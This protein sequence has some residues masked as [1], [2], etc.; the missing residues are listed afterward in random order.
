MIRQ[1][2]LIASCLSAWLFYSCTE[3]ND[4]EKALVSA[5]DSTSKT[6]KD[7]GFIAG[8][9]DASESVK[10]DT[11]SGE[12]AEKINSLSELSRH[13]NK[14]P[15][16]FVIKTN[17]D[18]VIK[19]KEG[20]LLSIPANAFLNASNQSPIVGEVKISVKEFYKISDMMIAG[21][22]TASNNQLLE[23]GGMIN[24]KATAKENNDS[25]ILRP[26]KSIVIAMPNQNTN[27]V[28]GM[29]LFNGVHGDNNHTDNNVNWVPQ[30]GTTGLVQ[31]WNVRGYDSYKSLFQIEPGF[32]FPD[33]MPRSKPLIVNSNPEHLQ[34]EIKMPVRDLMQ[35]AGT[36]TRK[37]YGYIDT[38]GNFHCHRIGNSPQKILF[39]GI[40]GPTICQNTKV[41]LPVEANVSFK[42][43]LNYNY[44][45]KLFKMGKGKPDSLVSI[46]ATLKPAVKITSVEKIRPVYK[47]AVTVMEYRK[48]QARQALLLRKYEEKL[49]QLQ[50]DDEEKLAKLE[51]SGNMNLQSAQNYF[52]MSTPGL[53]WI[54]CDRFYNSQAKVDYFVKLKEP[55]SLLIV[56][57]SIK[58]IISASG[59]GV[60]ASVPLNE[61][62]TIVGLKTEQGRLMMAMHETTVTK[63]SFDGLSFKP[64]TV[65]EYRSQ[66]EKLNRF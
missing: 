44:F 10:A 37:A 19:C 48:K 8:N 39:A 58:S 47:N 35:P 32:L 49:K 57:S 38:S 14:K 21:L 1:K 31:N 24:I 12:V 61:K 3:S 52:L 64:V 29:Q 18:T 63:E 26:G 30:A 54:N 4:S 42:S 23:T 65:K 28:E 17:R 50:L 27:S 25:C 2:L 46:T 9:T 66:L 13:L 11:S 20:T 60:F 53:G 34:A 51:S 36:I 45:Q 22:S 59:D 5:K 55:A 62:I 6:I 40:Y 41:N 33:D 15:S 7:S 16:H 43:D 56:F